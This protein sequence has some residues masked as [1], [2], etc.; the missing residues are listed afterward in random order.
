MENKYLISY[1]PKQDAFHA[2]PIDEE[3]EINN[4]LL[5]IGMLGDCLDMFPDF[6]PLS[7]CNE[8]EVGATIDEYKKAFKESK[9]KR[10][11]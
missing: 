9:K 4:R 1:S 11:K 10:K 8:D 2:G 6:I 5:A 7:Y 3:L